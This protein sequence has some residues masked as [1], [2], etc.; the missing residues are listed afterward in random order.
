MIQ[1]GDRLGLGTMADIAGISLLT[2][3]TLCGRRRHN[4]GTPVMSLGLNVGCIVAADSL[5]V[6]IVNLGPCAI[7]VA[8][9]CQSLG[10]NSGL[11]STGLILVHLAAGTA[12]PVLIVTGLGAGC[13]L[14]LSLGHAV[15]QSIDDLGLSLTALRA[16]TGLGAFLGTG[17]F[18]SSGP[19]APS[20]IA[21]LENCHTQLGI[22][23]NHSIHGVAT[24]T[25]GGSTGSG[26]GILVNAVAILIQTAQ[27]AAAAIDLQL[28]QYLAGTA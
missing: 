21:K 20:M 23:R 6:N 24:D 27:L 17:G 19:I 9:N 4:A 26:I 16:S 5:M 14:S 11:L 13:G 22:D 25:A 12:G 7:G 10:C 3:N 8:Q 2:C 15:T 28:L 18:L 1:C